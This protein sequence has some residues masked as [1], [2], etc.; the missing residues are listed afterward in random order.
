VFE[1]NP[2]WSK[3]DFAQSMRFKDLP[4]ELQRVLSARKRG[5][6]KTPTKVPVS[7]RLSADV[8][9]ALRASGEGW[10]SRVDTCLRDWIEK[11][12]TA[13]KKAS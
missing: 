3:E 1:E 10:Q 4:A 8:V 6:Q 9:E 5:P 7:I 11:E 12:A 2:P 13:L